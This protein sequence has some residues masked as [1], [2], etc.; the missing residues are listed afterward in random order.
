MAGISFEEALSS[1][2]SGTDTHVLE[3]IPEAYRLIERVQ[4]DLDDLIGEKDAHLRASVVKACAGDLAK[5]AELIEGCEP[6]NEHYD[7]LKDHL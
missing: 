7:E 2:K 6:Y 3:D 4:G 5:A 1:V